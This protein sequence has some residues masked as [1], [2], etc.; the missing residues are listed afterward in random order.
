MQ[1]PLSSKCWG[2]YSI[3]VSIWVFWGSLWLLGF[4]T[5]ECQLY[6]RRLW[7]PKMTPQKHKSSK[8]ARSSCLAIVSG[9][10]QGQ[11]QHSF[12]SQD[13]Q[14]FGSTFTNGSKEG[15][16]CHKLSCKI[17]KTSRHLIL[18]RPRQMLIWQK[19]CVIYRSYKRLRIVKH[20]QASTIIPQV[21]N[22]TYF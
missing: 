21:H 20:W 3:C 10:S 7:C 19:C 4:M 17:P 18:P 2:L 11:H 1:W 12:R 16:H 22:F 15:C 5:A 13:A 9:R 8:R 14:P 6:A